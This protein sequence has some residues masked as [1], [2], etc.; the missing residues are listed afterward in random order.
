MSLRL[1]VNGEDRFSLA[2]PLTPLV[3]VLRDEFHLTG[4]KIVCREGFCGACTVLLDGRPVMSCLVPVGLAADCEVRTVESLATDGVL[5]PLQQAMEQ[6]DAVQCGMCFPGMLMSLTSFLEREP[7]P[8]RDDIKA[9]LAG[10]I[11]RCTGYERIVDAAL[12][13]VRAE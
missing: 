5:S 10:N 2:E 9:A 1:N 8:S 6:H 13:V 11:C 7:N 3:D 4:A 12:S